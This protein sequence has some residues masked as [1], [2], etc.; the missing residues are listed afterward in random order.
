MIQDILFPF[1]IEST[2]LQP[3]DALLAVPGRRVPG[4]CPGRE[5]VPFVALVEPVGLV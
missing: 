4:T 3:H 1:H 2:Y 5:H